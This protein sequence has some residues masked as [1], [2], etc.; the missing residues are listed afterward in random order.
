[1]VNPFISAWTGGV[2]RVEEEVSLHGG[3]FGSQG[4][5]LLTE[6][7]LVSEEL[8]STWSIRRIG[9]Y[10]IFRAWKRVALPILEAEACFESTTERILRRVTK[11]T[12][13]VLTLPTNNPVWQAIPR[14]MNA[15]RQG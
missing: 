3:S 2:D 13:K 4:G 7:F 10:M 14:T 6:P 8:E 15:A 11:H 1:M 5:T 12:E 9:I